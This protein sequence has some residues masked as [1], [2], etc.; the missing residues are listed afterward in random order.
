MKHRLI[1]VLI[2]LLFAQCTTKE[3]PSAF[4]E[5]IDNLFSSEFKSGE[6][7]SC[8]LVLKGDSTLFLKSYGLADLVTN[9][10]ISSKTLFNLGSISK[11]FVAYGILI[12]RDEGKLSLDDPIGKY[13]PDFKNKSIAASVTIRHL[14]THTSGLPDIRKVREDSVFYL[15]AKDEENLAPVMQ[16]DSLLF[17]PGEY[18]EYSNPAFNALALII[19]Q[20][21]EMKWQKF[22]EERI[23]KPAGMLSST[24]TDGPHPETGVSH[25]YININGI[26]TEKDY[27]EELTFAAAGNGGV[28]SS[29]D[30]LIL[31]ERAMEKA[32]FISPETIT[33][34]QQVY[35][36]NNW[37]GDHE[38]FI[39][40]SWFID[41]TKAGDKI[42]AHTGTQGGFYCHFVSVP[43]QDILY[44][45]LANRPYN[46]ESDYE[47]VFS[48]LGKYRLVE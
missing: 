23:F 13:F 10:S 33:E 2:T 28:W 25:G 15:T 29:V 30:E 3:K 11:P 6:P 1:P 35:K 26:W 16:A 47:E 39:A 9:E 48:I 40:T 22:I 45:V 41:S 27:G 8:V 7:G 46:R 37:K 21:S 17:N 18:Y 32:L 31:F 4:S 5:E 24:I 34:S 38:P 14:L 42:V 43:D 12:L 19:E 36:P 44:I 20:V